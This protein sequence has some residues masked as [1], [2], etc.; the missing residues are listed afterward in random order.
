MKR[1]IT[2]L[3]VLLLLIS[4][5]AY[6]ADVRGC[7]VMEGNSGRLLFEI[8]GNRALPNASTTKIL[9][10]LIALECSD[11]DEIVT[12]S[13]NAAGTEGSSMY[14]HAGEKIRMENLIK[15]L[16]I[17]SGNDAA[18][19]IAEHIDGTVQNFA[20]RMNRRA[21][22]LGAVN[23][24]F[25]NPHGL[26]ET[27]HYTTA[28]DLT[29]I[30]VEAMKNHRFRSIVATRTE[31][32]CDVSGETAHYLKSKNKILWTVEGGCGIKTGY[33]SVAGR[34]LVSGAE[35]G[36]M[37]AVC[38]VLY[39]PQMWEDSARLLEEVFDNYRMECVFEQDE[40]L[41]Q[42]PVADGRSQ[43]VTVRAAQA[44]NLP[45]R[46][47]GSEGFVIKYNL[48]KNLRAP[49]IKGQS[50]GSV[51]VSLGEQ[52]WTVGLVSGEACAQN[53]VQSNLKRVLNA[54]LRRME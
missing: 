34:C 30:A 12:V 4:L 53:T 44:L 50:L 21:R 13:G 31:T 42:L 49:V 6:A 25:T 47:D 2:S 29:R 35:R 8:N 24:C 10:A 51:T 20:A 1:C 17:V 14:L 3:I 23:T 46:I 32:V 54:F 41:M 37:L 45:I 43:N 48:E 22:E 52:S 27:G 7:A 28:E 5:T 11:P 38:T 36:G 39:A 19:A 15:G 33:T 40:I 18:V 9:T 16:L 26:N